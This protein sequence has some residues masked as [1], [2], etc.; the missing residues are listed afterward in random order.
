VLRGLADRGYVLKDTG[1]EVSG[2]QGVIVRP[3]GLEGGADSRREG[4]VLTD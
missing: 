1:A 4:L 3:H 2:I